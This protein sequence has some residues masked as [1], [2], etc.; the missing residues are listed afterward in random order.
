M[1]NIIQ[2]VAQKV[3]REIEKNIVNV[4]EGS[5]NL[6]DI[7]DSVNEVINNIG[8]DTLSFIIKELDKI[9]LELPGRT[10]KYHVHKRDVKRTLITKFGELEFERSYFK[11]IKEDRFVYILDEVLDID[12][13]ERI[14]SNLK[15]EILEKS[16]DVSYQKAADLS[17]PVSLTRESVKRI[18][19]ENGSIDNLALEVKEKNKEVKTIYIEAD[20]DHV[21]IQNGKN[22]EMKLIYVY[23]DKTKVNR[24]RIKLENVRYFTGTMD[25]EELWTEVATY[26]DEAYDLEKVEKIYIAGDGANWIKGGTEIINNSKFVLDHYHLSKY[27]KVITGHLKSLDNPMDID[28]PLWKSLRTKNKKLTIELIDLAIEETPSESRKERMKEAKNYILNNWEGIINLF[29]EKKYKCSAEGH[30]SHILS[31]R[32]SSRP[33][34]W[35]LVGAD[36]MARMRAFKANGGSLKKYYKENRTKKRKE[37]RILELDQRVVKNAKRKYNTIDPDIMID[38]PYTYKTKGKWLKN[39]LNCSGF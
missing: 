33:M 28:K 38:M 32:L 24:G 3:K 36:E 10:K 27:I 2:L 20:E 16:V 19:R 1:N 26:L 6:Y 25:P 37:A 35:S 9:I 29:G 14:E 31:A 7:V 23:D 15:S 34:S 11:N 4:L 13:Y 12:K 8:L 30:I 18:I 21:P 39:M 17:T 5:S 22:K